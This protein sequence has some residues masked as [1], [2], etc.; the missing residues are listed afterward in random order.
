MSGRPWAA[1]GSLPT[2]CFP[3][4]SPPCSPVVYLIFNEG[5][6]GRSEL[7]TE[8]LRLGRALAERMP[9]ESEVQGL[10]ATMLLHD[11][12]RLARFRGGELVLLSDQD[13][14]SGTR[15]R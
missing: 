11:S 7:S 2:T 5:Y 15:H 6:G 3:I 1:E 9:D 13:A 10:L 4:G 14:R 12:R 8:A